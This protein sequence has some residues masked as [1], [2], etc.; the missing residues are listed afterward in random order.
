[1]SQNHDYYQDLLKRLCKAEHISTRKPR[2]ENIDDFVVIHVKNHLK[3]GVDLEC[4]KILD[5]IQRTIVPLG[6][7]FNQQLYL[8]Q[9]EIDWIE[10]R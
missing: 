9:K 5:L 10:W 7:K 6:I 4:F 8:Y 2:F 3:E 1:M